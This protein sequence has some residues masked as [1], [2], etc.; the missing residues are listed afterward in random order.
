MIRI[1]SSNGIFVFFRNRGYIKT[2]GLLALSLIS[3]V[4]CVISCASAPA[5]LPLWAVSPGAVAQ[6]YPGEKYIAQ[7]GTG[8]TRQN[9]ELN[10]LKV[11]DK[12]IMYSM[13]LG[14]ILVLLQL[15]P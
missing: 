10:A 3:V 7:R 15:I 8:E 1:K 2:V 11:R 9:A 13:P 4:L 6:V 5:A 14:L 12:V